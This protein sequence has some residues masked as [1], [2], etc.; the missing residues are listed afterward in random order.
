MIVNSCVPVL[1]G[2]RV[3]SGTRRFRGYSRIP[4]SSHT[5]VQKHGGTNDEHRLEQSVSHQ[6]GDYAIPSHDQHWFL[7]SRARP[8]CIGTIGHVAHGKSTVVKAI[9]GVQVGFFRCGLSRRP[10]VSKTSWSEISP[11]S[12]ATRMQRSTSATIPTVLRTRLPPRANR[13][14]LTATRPSAQTQNPIPSANVPV[15]AAPC[16]C[17]ATCPSSTVPDTTSSWRPCLTAPPSWMRLSF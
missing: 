2:I 10:S 14:V 16:P 9:S 12:S 5:T 3:L 11:S 4:R 8:L 15:A 17:F 7:A 13:I 6:P 1:V